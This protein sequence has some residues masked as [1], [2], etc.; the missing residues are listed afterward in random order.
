MTSNNVPVDSVDACI[1][2]TQTSTTTTT[3][4]KSD[5]RE[6]GNFIIYTIF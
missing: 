5:N 6:N 1:Q 3:I 4:L 2:M